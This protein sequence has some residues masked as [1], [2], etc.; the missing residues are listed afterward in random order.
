M[1]LQPAL[2]VQERPPRLAP[3]PPVAVP[4]QPDPVVYVVSATADARYPVVEFGQSVASR[5]GAHAAPACQAAS[6]RQRAATAAA[7]SNPPPNFPRGRRARGERQGCATA[8]W[9]CF[10]GGSPRLQP[11]GGQPSRTLNST[12][13]RAAPA[14]WSRIRLARPV[15]RPAADMN[16]RG[17]NPTGR[18]TAS[19]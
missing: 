9:A 18:A 16:Q 8:S 13:Y 12:Y 2:I 15:R 17:T 5:R 10:L 11:P 19:P 1:G 14:R 7:A 3:L 6:R 4:A